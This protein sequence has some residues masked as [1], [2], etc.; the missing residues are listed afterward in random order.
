MKTISETDALNELIIHTEKQRDYELV[1][2]KEQFHTV[3]DSI[4]PINLIKNAFRDLTSSPDIKEDVVGSAIGLGSGMLSKKFLIGNTNN[5]IKK[6]L[7]TVAEF[8]IANLV[9][10][11]SGGI[12]A[13][14]GALLKSFFNKNKSQNKA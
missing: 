13:I 11:Y 3:Y 7:G 9:T 5:P 2:L 10:K 8:A 4:K 1:L 12:T 14:G 6:V